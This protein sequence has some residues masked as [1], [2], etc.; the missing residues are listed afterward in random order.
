MTSEI[1]FLNDLT[2]S[3]EKRLHL[4]NTS[5]WTVNVDDSLTSRFLIWCFTFSRSTTS[6]YAARAVLHEGLQGYRGGQRD[7]RPPWGHN[8]V[9]HDLRDVFSGWFNEPPWKEFTSKTHLSVDSGRRWHLNF[10]FH[11]LT[12]HDLSVRSSCFG[13]WR[14]TGGTQPYMC[15][16]YV[17]LVVS[18][19]FNVGF[20]LEKKNRNGA[21]W[22]EQILRS[23][24]SELN[25]KL[26]M[27]YFTRTSTPGTRTKKIDHTF[28]FWVPDRGRGILKPCKH[29]YFFDV[30]VF[31]SSGNL[32]I[33]ICPTFRSEGVQVV[34]PSFW[35]YSW[36]LCHYRARARTINYQ[37]HWRRTG[38]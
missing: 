28:Y 14:F 13:P 3:S 21:L 17:L 19:P 18:P 11:N 6:Q 16:Y 23:E 9:E 24:A 26:S 10:V 27:F 29:H 7:R 31:N 30:F 32:A 2:N 20:R 34:S 12:K 38:S 1:F 4:K 36:V 25:I 37:S 33:L 5:A 8:F 35:V 22:A 15:H